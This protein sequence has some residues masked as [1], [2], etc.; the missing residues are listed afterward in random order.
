M[1]TTTHATR[2]IDPAAPPTA[3][4]RSAAAG[5]GTAPAGQ[6]L[7]RA[8]GAAAIAGTVPYLTLKVLWLAGHP[9]GV[10][11]PELLGQLRALN[12][13]TV[14]LDACVIGLALALM[15]RS[16]RRVPAW[17]VLLPAWVGTGFLVPM[18][19]VILPGTLLSVLGVGSGP[20]GAADPLQPWVRPLVYGGL[21][22]QGVF[23]AVAFVL[24]ARDRWSAELGTG[25]GAPGARARAVLPLLRVLAVGGSVVALLAVVLDLVAAA[26]WGG[27]DTASSTAV[28]AALELIG[29]L[30]VTALAR[31]TGR[32]A[33]A[34]AAGW[35]GSAVLFSWGLW[36][37]VNT[38]G[39]TPLSAAGDPL[40]G[41]SG[42]CALLAG[43]AL[44]VAGLVALAGT[45]V[46]RPPATVKG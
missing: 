39:G 17:L 31:D 21:A 22:W 32:R 15:L 7:R 1:T 4:A 27:W 18:A 20:G 12:A 37:T 42:L 40:S 44:A 33:A 34:V 29:V 28:K 46:A 2:T 23:R 11:R 43:F 35:I 25:G 8:A 3:H 36:G 45:G 6:L 24:Y 19:M 14:V 5:R 30:G 13:V 26:R 9:V 41:L 10:R 16:G 38:V